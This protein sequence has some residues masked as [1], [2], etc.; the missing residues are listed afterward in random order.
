MP[1]I[2]FIAVANIQHQRLPPA[3]LRLSQHALPLRGLHQ[4]GVG[5]RQGVISKS[6]QGRCGR[7]WPTTAPA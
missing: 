7:M 2:P 4:G 3:G 5:S 6:L 1:G